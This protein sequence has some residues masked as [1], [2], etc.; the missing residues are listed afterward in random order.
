METEI[1]D[2][3][4]LQRRDRDHDV[5]I[6]VI[7]VITDRIDRHLLRTS[8]CAG[9]NTRSLGRQRRPRRVLLSKRT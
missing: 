1:A 8:Q 6:A 5:D 4:A 2:V 9:T 3:H 7:E